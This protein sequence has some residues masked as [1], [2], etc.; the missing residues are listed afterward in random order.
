MRGLR[1]LMMYNL[2]ASVS[3]FLKNQNGATA[4]EYS[5]IAAAMTIAII[6]AMPLIS[7]PL[8]SKFSL[9]GSTITNIK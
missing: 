1:T 2:K 5:M 4:I 3:P 7:D 9:V 6:A 8:S